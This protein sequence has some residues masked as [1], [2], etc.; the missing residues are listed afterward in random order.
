MAKLTDRIKLF[1]VQRLAC[2]D[3][4]QTIADAVGETFGV[5]I[6]RQ[7]VEDYDPSKRGDVAEKWRVLHHETRSAFVKDVASIG[8]AH[9]NYRLR[10]LERLYRKASSGSRPNIVLAKELLEQ[11]AKEMGEA[12]TNRRI[13]TTGDPLRELAHLLGYT[14]E[15]LAAAIAPGD[16]AG[17]TTAEVIH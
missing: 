7:Q 3:S 4:P 15:Q 13:L 6:P 16:E 9:R 17:I 8:V 12:Y 10:E 11:A 2:F 1:I 14:P 5:T